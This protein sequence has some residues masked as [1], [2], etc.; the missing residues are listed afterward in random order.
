MSPALIQLGY[1]YMRQGTF[2]ERPLD[3]GYEMGRHLI[4]QA[5]DIDPQSGSAWEHAGGDRDIL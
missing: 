3:E 4:E 2:G 5:L 1:A